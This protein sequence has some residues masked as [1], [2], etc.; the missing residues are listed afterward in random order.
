[1]GRSSIAAEL[2]ELL[3]RIAQEY[4]KRG[5]Y[6]CCSGQIWTASRVGSELRDSFASVLCHR[7][8]RSQ[9]RLL[10]PTHEAQQVERL[11]AGQAMLW[12]TSGE[13]MLVQM[14]MTTAADVVRVATMIDVGG[15]KSAAPTVHVQPNNNHE[16][17][18]NQPQSGLECVPLE[19]L[20]PARSPL[21]AEHARIVQAFADGKDA[22]AIVTELTGMQSKAGKPYQEKLKEVQA[23][24]RTALTVGR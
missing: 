1:M 18:L 22:G 17:S 20:K 5:V 4:R 10:L 2:G 21:S 14:P 3:E 13:A 6:A 11:N 23:A 12:R 24:I 19:S 7:M 9:A 15:M 8:K 16:S